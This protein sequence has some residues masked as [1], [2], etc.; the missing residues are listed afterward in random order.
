MSAAVAFQ[1]LN[2]AYSF[3]GFAGCLC[4]AQKWPHGSSDGNIVVELRF[5]NVTRL[6]TTFCFVQTIRNALVLGHSCSVTPVEMHC[7]DRRISKQRP[8]ME[9][10]LPPKK[11]QVQQSILL[12]TTRNPAGT[13]RA[14][15]SPPG[16]HA[17]ALSRLH[18]CHRPPRKPPLL[19]SFRF[20][21]S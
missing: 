16:A 6:L 11:K 15:I 9:P 20:V 1:V 18:A 3:C 4:S 19:A 13:V 17:A 7:V 14:A 21:I 12:L 2:G 5:V 10:R 8:C